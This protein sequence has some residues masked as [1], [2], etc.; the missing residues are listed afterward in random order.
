[1]SIQCDAWKSTALS[2]KSDNAQVGLAR[3]QHLPAARD[4]FTALGLSPPAAMTMAYTVPGAN[5]GLRHAVRQADEDLGSPAASAVDAWYI[6]SGEFPGDA[7]G[8]SGGRSSRNLRRV[9]WLSTDIDLH[10]MIAHDRYGATALGAMSP[11]DRARC[12]DGAKRE[13]HG[14]D[15]GPLAD[16]TGDALARALDARAAAGLPEPGAIVASGYGL[17][18]LW[19]V[20]PAVGLAIDACAGA[21]RAIVARLNAAAGYPM[22]DPVSDAGTRILR[23]PGTLNLKNP[24][25]PRRCQILDGGTRRP[26]DIAA[27][28]DLAGS[29]APTDDDGRSVEPQRDDRAGSDRITVSAAPDAIASA[30]THYA[31]PCAEWGVGDRPHALDPAFAGFREDEPW[32]GIV[33]G[34]PGSYKSA[35][36]MTVAASVAMHRREPVLYVGYEDSERSRIAR[37]IAA[38]ARVPIRDVR[39]AAAADPNVRRR[40]EL[41]AQTLAERLDTMHLI[42]GRR[43]MTADQVGDAAAAVARGGA[44][45][46]LIVVDA[47]QN[48]AAPPGDGPTVDRRREV[49][50]IMQTLEGVRDATPARVLVL[51]HAARGDGGYAVRLDGAKESSGIEYAADLA[52]TLH[53]TPVPIADPIE[54]P[55]VRLAINVEKSRAAGR[56]AMRVAVCPDTGEVRPWMPHDEARF[57]AAASDD[58]AGGGKRRTA[59]RGA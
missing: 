59:R 1:M 33:I 37:L 9:L 57:V 11:D 31:R 15:D 4:L 24:D 13:V 55:L 7:I 30:V 45:I 40:I 2:Q 19:G 5:T 42:C 44:G 17:Y 32:L 52:L 34:A 51:S 12:I 50:G 28:H 46:P 29:M 58:E 39:F 22:S 35:M 23:L 53:P 38:T 25:R 54:T 47:L 20:E 14:M 18:M 26:L 6:A 10:M 48:V 49:D 16:L 56:S 41:A 27:V 8:K 43:T 21:N 3:H 36:A